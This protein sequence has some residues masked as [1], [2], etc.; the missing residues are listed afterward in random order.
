MSLTKQTIKI[1]IVDDQTTSRL[2][3]RE[4]L[5][6]IGFANIPFA[7]DGEEALK[8]MMTSPAH[9]VISDYNM[10]KLNGLQLLQAIRTYP[11]TRITPFI[12]LTGSGDRTVLQQ[13]VKLG[14]NNYLPKP[15]Q[16]AALQKAI[17]AVTG[18]LP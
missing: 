13:A 14:V 15:V 8:M 7:K 11:A 16:P 10:P 1:L 17:Q 2:L 12:L 4:A 18:N 9:I 6:Q 5:Q 3:M